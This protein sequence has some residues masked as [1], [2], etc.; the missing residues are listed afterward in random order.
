MIVFLT[1]SLFQLTWLLNFMHMLITSPLLT[2]KRLFKVKEKGGEKNDASSFFVKYH[3]IL[4]IVILPMEIKY[5]HL[6]S[7]FI[8]HVYFYLNCWYQSSVVNNCQGR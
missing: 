1:P 5:L 8:P 4:F 7:I 6:N 3:S 2:T